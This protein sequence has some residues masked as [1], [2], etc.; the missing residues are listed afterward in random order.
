MDPAPDARALL[1]M[2]AR[3]NAKLALDDVLR[4]VCEE[5]S[6]GFSVPIATVSLRDADGELLRSVASV[7]LSEADRER[8]APFPVVE[9]A[10]Y[11]EQYGD[12]VYVADLQQLAR[13][14]PTLYRELDMRSVATAPL[15][16]DGELMGQISI[17][18]QG[19]ERPFGE[20]DAA[21]LRGM[22]DLTAQAI[23]NARL[24]AENR[25]QLEALRALY[26]GAHSLSVERDPEM[27]A[28]SVTATC[29]DTLGVKLAWIGLAE[30]DGRVRPF[31]HAP[32]DAK[33]PYEITVRW[34][35]A[36]T[37]QGPT[38]RAIRSRLPAHCTD[39]DADAA[40]APWSSSARGA[41]LRS[42]LALPLVSRGAVIGALNL[43]SESIGFFSPSRIQFF[44]AFADLAAAALDFARS[45][46]E[47]R[48]IEKQLMFADRMA[49]MGTLAAGVA[50]EINNPLAY[51]MTNLEL[52]VARLR[53]AAADMTTIAALEDAL[54]GASRMRDIVR[55][56]KMFSRGDDENHGPVDMRRVVEFA[57]GIAARE[58]ECRARLVRDLNDVPPV[59]GSESRLSQVFVNLLVNAAQSIAEGDTA[60]NEVRVSL[61]A[62]A[63][64]TIAVE[65]RDTGCGI[66]RENLARV[67]DPFFTTKPVGVGTGLGLSICHGIVSDHGGEV[68]VESQPG[69]GTTFT[70]HLPTAPESIRTET[71]ETTA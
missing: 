43:Y 45:A 17:T 24:F 63:D 37:A 49:S 8:I 57:V 36:E 31:T 10:R 22:A 69:R 18:S 29:V 51:V 39:L 20:E 47:R 23:E 9:Y 59:V 42:S 21:L 19:A 6:S 15:R 5:L 11:L 44:T 41:G 56:L 48:D 2:A 50:H 28:R 34:D 67:F 30:K 12:V 46:G 40:F 38:G 53:K 16:R 14:N 7:G 65:I 62:V 71:T 55:D 61:R 64:N 58:I 70:V 25:A 68:T 60:N 1:R 26:T 4:A 52:A 33:Y 13:P 27:V 32:P 66:P 35:D 54:T 3:L